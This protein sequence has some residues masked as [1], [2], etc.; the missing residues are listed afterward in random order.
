LKWTFSEEKIIFAGY[1]LDSNYTKELLEYLKDKNYAIVV[2]S[3]SGTTLEPALAFRILL[4]DLR[5]KYSENEIKNR[6][7]A[8]TDK[9]K[10]VLKELSNHLGLQTFVVPDDVGWR[11]SVLTAVWLLPIAIAWYNI[12]SLLTWAKEI[13]KLLLREK[14][15]Y[16]NPSFTYVLF[17]NTLL[18]KWKHIEILV[19][20]DMK[21]KYISSWW[22]QLFWESEGKNGKWIFPTNLDFTTDLHSVWQYIQDWQKNIFETFLEIENKINDIWIPFIKNDLDKLNYISGKTINFANSWAMSGTID[23][24]LEWWVSIGKISIPILNEYYIWQLL[25]FFEFSCALS[26]YMIDVNPFNQPWVEA[27]KK[28]MM[29]N[30]IK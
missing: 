19:N 7:I 22:K 21:L 25:Y 9:D 5:I 14:D 29:N 6:V 20:F 12:D 28:Y 23:A 11:F 27:Y 13:K 26:A 2:I 24:H 18:E 8:I 4:E 15:I 17:R 30:L 16:K 1:N 10:W 3:K